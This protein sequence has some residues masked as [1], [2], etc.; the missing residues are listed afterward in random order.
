[1]MVVVGPEVAEIVDGELYSG[2]RSSGMV[3]NA[4][5]ACKRVNQHASEALLYAE[6]KIDTD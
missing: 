4:A 1:M 6:S 2:S 5:V 3:R